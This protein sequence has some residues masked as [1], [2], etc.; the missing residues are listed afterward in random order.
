MKVCGVDVTP[1]WLAVYLNQLPMVQVLLKYK[2]D[3]NGSQPDGTP[4]IFTVMPHLDILAALLDAGANPNLLYHNNVPNAYWSAESPLMSAVG[5]SYYGTLTVNLAAAKLLLAHGANPNSA[6]GSGDTALHWAVNLAG[7]NAWKIGPER[8]EI[9]EVLLDHHADPNMR[10]NNG[11]TP[12]DL[13]KDIIAQ[14][15]YWPSA[16][17]NPTEQKAFARELADLL[18]QYG[19][20]DNLPDWDHIKLVASGAVILSPSSKETPMTGTA[21]PC[22]K[23]SSTFMNPLRYPPPGLQLIDGRNILSIPAYH[24]PIW[25]G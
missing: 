4:L 3:P 8:R 11:K 17:N 19:A 22:W 6:D 23:P 9:V 15:S 16:P 12:L 25:Q 1:L 7:R 21:S 14:T 18:R 20:L 10:N 24:F 13:L 2:A 5:N